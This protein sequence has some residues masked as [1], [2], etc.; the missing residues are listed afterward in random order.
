MR[1]NLQNE[2]AVDSLIPLLL[3]ELGS[4]STAVESVMKMVEEAVRDMDAAEKVLLAKHRSNPG[5]QQDLKTYI[6]GC[7]RVCTGNL[8]W[9]L[10]TDRYK[11]RDQSTGAMLHVTL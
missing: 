6:D 3:Y 9:S 11:I 1:M 2:Q 5:L 8:A 10:R 4:L 7:R